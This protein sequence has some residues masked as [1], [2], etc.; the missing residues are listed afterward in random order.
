MHKRDQ[1]PFLKCLVSTK[2]S[3][4]SLLQ[5]EWRSLHVFGYGRCHF[6]GNSAGQSHLIG[7]NTSLFVS[8][9]CSGCPSP[10]PG[11]TTPSPLS[12][13]S[14]PSQS[15]HQHHLQSKTPCPVDPHIAHQPAPCNLCPSL[16]PRPTPR[17]LHTKP[18]PL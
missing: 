4:S 11:I 12:S 9:P 7:I 3:T 5:E 10:V 13:P 1:I 8:L 16:H 15:P 17:S 14:P 6:L 18:R 2:S